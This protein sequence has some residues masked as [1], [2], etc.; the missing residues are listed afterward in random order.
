MNQ[1][2]EIET[3]VQRLDALESTMVAGIKSLRSR[4]EELQS[5]NQ[6]ESKNEP[7][8]A[9]DLPP[10]PK[11]APT[12]P[13]APPI[14]PPEKESWSSP[15][16]PTPVPPP[17]PPV[18]LEADDQKAANTAEPAIKP[19]EDNDSSLEMQFGRVWLVRLGM[20]LVITGLVLLGNYAYQ[21]WIRELANGTR[22]AGLL[23]CSVTLFETGRR[24][25][26]RVNLAAFG[27]VVAAGGLAFFYYCVFAAHHV[28]R[29]KVISNPILAATLLAA[30]AGIVAG[31]SW[32]RR[33]KA[34][35]MLGLSMA[36]YAVMLQPLGWLSC[37]S[38]IF[39]AGAGLFFMTRPGWQ[40]PGWISLLASYF[41]F[42]GW[43]L[44]VLGRQGANDTPL[45]FLP[46]V[47][48]LF[49][50]PD[51]FPGL[52]AEWSPISRAR[53]TAINN[54]A[55]FVLFSLFWLA[56]PSRHD[57]YWLACSGVGL[58]FL[59]L[60]ALGRVRRQK[61]SEAGVTQ[62]IACLSLALVLKL[63]GWHI[64]IGLAVESLALALV[65]ARF[66]TRVE[67]HFSL[68]AALGTAALLVMGTVSDR[69]SFMMPLWSGA[70]AC[71]LLAT[72]SLV[73]NHA[74]TQAKEENVDSDLL[75][76]GRG[77]AGMVF[78]L[79][80]IGGI[81]VWHFRVP[82][83][84]QAVTAAGLAAS[85][86]V[87]SFRFDPKC[88]W[89]EPAFGSLLWMG[90]GGFA[91]FLF[92]AGPIEKSLTAL[93]YLLLCLAWSRRQD[94]T[95]DINSNA[96]YWPAPI[97]SACALAMGCDALAWSAPAEVFCMAGA[98]L[99]FLALARLT[100]VGPLAAAGSVAALFAV[101]RATVADMTPAATFALTGIIAGGF[102]A[103][104]VPGFTTC[105]TKADA[106]VFSVLQR[107][108]LLAAYVLAWKLWNPTHYGDWLAFSALIPI[109]VARA[110][111]RMPP[112]EANALAAIGLFWWG[113]LSV[114]VAPR[115]LN[116]PEDWRGWGSVAAWG[117]LALTSS[118]S[119]RYVLGTL[120]SILAAVYATRVTHMLGGWR[121]VTVT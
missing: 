25:A 121:P 86:A 12:A 85:M 21:N 88:R 56:K 54:A 74:S 119:L 14:D 70:L 101:W 23:F 106:M 35:A 100:R 30:A 90:L 96:G 18:A 47:W 20:G 10:R 62:G 42:V 73:L 79:A 17:L 84:W 46:F 78:A 102:G 38:S 97:L 39:I 92:P 68:L 117:A 71:L 107:I 5:A 105:L 44:M 118:T 31:V 103:F 36:S 83:S 111:N 52:K 95:A 28:D 11:L 13:I 91:I 72:A 98:G 63:D 59:G 58:L 6:D 29:L 76:T 66:R 65:F 94:N 8:V 108:A 77:Y 93:G 51:V 1:T 53:F 60:G 75:W 3:L 87:A 81:T 110:L 104:L 22:L 27:E 116:T 49:A 69:E 33:A 41:S 67:M 80:M 82:E 89:P 26:K 61:G 120:F 114:E 109:I 15:A 16:D 113:N 40:M 48:L 24:L 19:R 50:L 34:T 57:D 45:S 43:Q 64:A 112:V 7:P 9:S 4:I 115:G 99:V 37:L 55:F 2:R 32:L